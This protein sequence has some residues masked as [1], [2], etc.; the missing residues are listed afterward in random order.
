MAWYGGSRQSG[1]GEAGQRDHRGPPAGA[2][3]EQLAGSSGSNGSEGVA[4]I[5]NPFYTGTPRTPVNT[6]KHTLIDRQEIIR[7]IKSKESRPSSPELERTSSRDGTL[8]RPTT[9]ILSTTL[10]ADDRPC[11]LETNKSLGMQ[12]ERPRSALHRGD[13]TNKEDAQSAFH[14][15]GDATTD[16]STRPFATSPVAPWHPDFPAPIF[17]QVRPEHCRPPTPPGQSLR[18]PSRP[19]AISHASLASSFVYKLPTS[20]LVQASRPDTPDLERRSSRSPDKARRHT[21]SPPYMQHTQ[22]VTTYPASAR[23]PP[24]LRSERAFP[25]QAHQPRRSLNGFQSLPHTHAALR[26]RR[27][28]LAESALHHAPMVGSY[29]ESILRGRMSTTPSKPLNFVAQIGVLGKGDCRP[30]LRCP[31]HVIVPFP[32]VFYSY[33]SAANVTDQ[34]SPYVG[35]IDLENTLPNPGPSLERQRRTL[36]R[37]E[38]SRT[39]SHNHDERSASEGHQNHQRKKQKRNHRSRSASPKAKTPPGGSYRIPPQGQLQIILKNPNKTAVK[40]FLVP[41]DVSD[42]MPGQ[43]TFIRQRCY[44]AAG[45]VIDM[46][47]SARRN[48]GTDRPEAALN[49]SEDGDMNEKPVLRYLIHL[50]L[51]CVAKGR[52]FLYKAVR[53]VFANRVPDGK[54]SLRC[55]V[56]MPGP[57]YSAY[58]PA[59]DSNVGAAA[60]TDAERRRSEVDPS[61]STSP[62]LAVYEQGRDD[63]GQQSGRIWPPASSPSRRRFAAQSLPASEHGLRFGSGAMPALPY[64]CDI[65]RPVRLVESRGLVGWQQ[66]EASSDGMEL[67]SEQSHETQ[68][69]RSLYSP[70]IGQ[71]HGQVDGSEMDT[72]PACLL[73]FAKPSSRAMY[74]KS[75]APLMPFRS[76]GEVQGLDNPFT[77]ERDRSREPKPGARSESLLARRLKDLAMRCDG[78]SDQRQTDG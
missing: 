25:Y 73:E 11:S 38:S 9:P 51:C 74:S 64:P 12:I 24:Q 57:R 5:Y 61:S 40:L 14:R 10:V 68:S 13:F 48:L 56:Q 45:P 23:Q 59:Q 30:S 39:G 47:L 44:S 16:D 41:Y 67:D 78:D 49:T 28:S 62:T 8:K 71:Q 22:T 72:D 6:S 36:H 75:T 27:P 69:P 34:P 15:F 53:V 55:E 70:A 29:E 3:R 66:R 42:M 19:R 35:L 33:P 60:P 76:R 65:Q 46:P 63:A 18:Q 7:R 4:A 2:N 32:A 26:T 37:A 1:N 77:F 58:K 52:Y 54:E 50:N 17:R 31:P 43:K 20:P 21:F